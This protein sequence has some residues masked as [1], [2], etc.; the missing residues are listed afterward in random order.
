MRRVL[1][2][3]SVCSIFLLNGFNYVF[4]ALPQN[5]FAFTASAFAIIIHV[6]TPHARTQA[7]TRFTYI[8]GYIVIIFIAGG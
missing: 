8:H 5:V 3:S 1:Q 4:K 7:Y 6:K 2:S